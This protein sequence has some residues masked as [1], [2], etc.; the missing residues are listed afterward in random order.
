MKYLIRIATV[1]LAVISL[2]PSAVGQDSLNVVQRGKVTLS[3][4]DVSRVDIQGNYAYVA[5]GRTGL[6]IMDISNPTQPEEVGYCD[7]PGNAHAVAVSGDYAY[8]A[9]MMCDLRVID[10]SVPSSPH[11]VAHLETGTM[12][13]DVDCDEQYVYLVDRWD[14]LRVIDVSNPLQPTIVGTFLLTM[15]NILSV[16]VSGDCAYIGDGSMRLWII[17]IS[18][19]NA[20]NVLATFPMQGIPVGMSVAA[21]MAYVADGDMVIVDVSEPTAPALVGSCS[22]SGGARDVAISGNHA[23]VPTYWSGLTAVNISTPSNPYEVG[24]CSTNGH[25]DAIAISHGYAYIA[26]DGLSVCDITIPSSPALANSYSLIGE[27]ERVDVFDNYAYVAAGTPGLKIVDITVSSSPAVV[28]SLETYHANDVV[29]QGDYAYIADDYFGLKVVDVLDP[30]SPFI[31]G[32]YN[33]PGYAKALDVSGEYAY[34]ADY[35]GGF[36]VV[37][38]ESPLNP[39]EVAACSSGYAIDVETQGNY[40]Y[41]VDNSLLIFDITDP[42]SP[43]Q[44]GGYS[45]IESLHGITVSGD[46]AYVTYLFD[47]DGVFGLKVIDI[48]IPTSPTPLGSVITPGGEYAYSLRVMGDYLYLANGIAGLQVYD[49][50]DPSNPTEAGFYSPSYTEAKALDVVEGRAYLVDE[51]YLRVMDFLPVTGIEPSLPTHVPTDFAITSI[52]PNPFNPISNI[53][54]SLPSSEN[55][56]LVI[57]NLQG[58]EVTRLVDGF[59]APGIYCRTFDASYLSSGVYFALLSCRNSQQMKKLILVK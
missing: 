56:S 15:S 58:R 24:S 31:C 40:A 45:G 16:E 34:L 39:Y 6:R 12:A 20:P 21:G 19:P 57:Y 23:Y 43:Y 47:S 33:T 17:D 38:V 5:S 35:E 30:G 42:T 27:M 49:I 7:T 4:G 1:L 59:H 28:S 3:W 2:S 51:N 10:I 32:S 46:Y 18:E 13:Y 11:E 53:V 55:V 41:V 14:G 52:Y 48:S 50:S 26:D 22:I 25:A 29:V 37:N 54:F 9:D 44:V 8:V 36:R